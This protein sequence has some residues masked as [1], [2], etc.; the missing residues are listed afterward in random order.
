MKTHGMSE[1]EAHAFIQLY[2]A[3]YERQLGVE[4][5]HVGADGDPKDAGLLPC[6]DDP[7]SG[8]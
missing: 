2:G 8:D 1:V 7:A 5:L 6:G 4:S 3:R